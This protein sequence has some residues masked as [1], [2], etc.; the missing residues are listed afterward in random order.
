LGH[1]SSTVVN[2][3]SIAAVISWAIFKEGSTKGLELMQS[4]HTPLIY[5]IK[6]K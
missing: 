2:S 4:Q 5:P 6:D 1:E 3:R